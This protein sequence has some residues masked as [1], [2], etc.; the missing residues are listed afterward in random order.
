[1]RRDSTEDKIK[2]DFYKLFYQ[3]NKPKLLANLKKWRA[4]KKKQK[5]AKNNK[6]TK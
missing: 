1:M 3:E 4:K 6:T 5:H 2:K